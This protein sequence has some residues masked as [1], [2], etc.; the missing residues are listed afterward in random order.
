MP[1]SIN[2]IGGS[3]GPE[4]RYEN[5]LANAALCNEVRPGLIYFMPLQ[6]DKGSRL[7]LA[8][9]NGR[10]K[11]SDLGELLT[12]EIDFLSRLTLSDC[13]YFAAHMLNPVQLAGSLP[14]D[15]EKMLRELRD[16][17]AYYREKGMLSCQLNF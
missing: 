13:T 4:R 5:A 7:A 12:E 16:G 1:F 10:F 14:E 17:L 2:I 15:R 3:A 9:E 11:K 8:V 6:I